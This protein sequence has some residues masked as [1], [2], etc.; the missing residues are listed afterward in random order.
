MILAALGAVAGYSVYYFTDEISLQREQLAKDKEA[1]FE[2]FKVEKDTE[3]KNLEKGNL[4]LR[5]D[6]GILEKSNLKAAKEVAT[7]QIEVADAKRRQSEAEIKLAEVRKRQEARTFEED[8]FLF[9]LATASPGK[10]K[11]GYIQGVPEPATL[12]NKLSLALRKAKWNV[13]EFKPVV[14]VIE[15]GYSPETEVFLL[16]RDLDNMNPSQQAL[17]RALLKAGFQL[18]TTRDETVPA[19]ISVLWVGPKL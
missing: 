8:I 5:Q 6:V 3:I 11:I 7:L 17:Q 16:M 10:I 15:R 4:K 18:Q 2:R 14:S 19:G 13:L 1:E 12:A 9:I